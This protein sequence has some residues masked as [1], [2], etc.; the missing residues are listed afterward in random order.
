M[1][2][3]DVKSE[4]LRGWFYI[5]AL[6]PEG[7]KLVSDKGAAPLKAW[8]EGQI[9]EKQLDLLCFDPLVKTHDLEENDNGAIERVIG[10]LATLAITHNLA[11]DAPHH[12]SKGTPDPGNA[13]RGRGASSF[14]DGGRLVYTLAAMSEAE[15]EQFGIGSH[16]RQRFIRLDAGK[17]N[18]AASGKTKWFELLGV[19]LGNHTELYPH[20][21]EIQVAA[22]WMPPDTWA[23]L[24]ND[25]L[26]TALTEIDRG[27]PDG[28]LYSDGPRAKETAAWSVVRNHCPDKTEHQCREII[29][30]WLKNG[31]LYSEE[32]MNPTSRNKQRG[33]EARPCQE[34]LVSRKF[35]AVSK[36]QQACSRG[37]K[38]IIGC[39]RQTG[40]GASLAIS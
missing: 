35:G 1:L 33:V 7:G 31:V 27:L 40:S 24:S 16:D 32:Y 20:G 6:P 21:D 36:W 8:V 37:C 29:R 30:T 13:D 18:L 25:A 5:V 15:A 17:V 10:T 38:L 11:V 3:Y 2:Y 26:N 14:K 9:T 22:P 19:K 34:A 23:G 4:D 12:I 28:R 39:K